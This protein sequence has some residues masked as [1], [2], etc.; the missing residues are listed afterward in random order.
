MG[1]QVDNE[2]E[3]ALTGYIGAPLSWT[4]SA[5]RT[6]G[7]RALNRARLAAVSRADLLAELH[8]RTG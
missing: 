5:N 7:G 2:N 3:E 1:T 8:A 4:E 6:L